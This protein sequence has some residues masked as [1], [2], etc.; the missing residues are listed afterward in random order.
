MESR[1]ADS[2]P[3]TNEVMDSFLLAC[4]NCRLACERNVE[5]EKRDIVDDLFCSCQFY[6]NVLCCF[7]LLQALA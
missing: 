2:L 4:C 7:I 6:H 5:M 1:S 3:T